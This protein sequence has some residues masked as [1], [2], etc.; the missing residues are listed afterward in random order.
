M[1]SAKAINRLPG[2]LRSPLVLIA[3]VIVL[4][5]VLFFSF[6][7]GAKHG[8]PPTAFYDVKRGDFVVSVVEGGTIEAVNEVVIRNEVEGTAR[9][10][11]IVPEGSYV[12][13]GDRLVELDSSQAQDQVNQQ[14]IAFQKAQF[15]FI[16]AQAQ[17][18]IQRS[19]TNS[20]IDAAALKLKLAEL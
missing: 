13:K 16:Q 7:G 2:P 8:L 14:D 15:A 11:Y 1:S 19:Q 6:R 5:T 12:Q 17:L 9:I 10:I 4:G 3:A 20:D 18:D